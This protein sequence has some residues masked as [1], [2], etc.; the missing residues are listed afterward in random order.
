MRTSPLSVLTVNT[1]GNVATMRPLTMDAAAPSAFAHAEEE[2]DAR[3]LTHLRLCF[4]ETFAYF[5][6][7]PS[8]AKHAGFYSA[9]LRRDAK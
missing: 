2:G 8:I 4:T 5:S 7:D 6:H 9:V 3:K 1:A